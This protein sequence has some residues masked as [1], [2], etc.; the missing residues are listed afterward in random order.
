MK[1][2]WKG[3]SIKPI[4]IGYINLFYRVYKKVIKRL[5]ISALSQRVFMKIL[6]PTSITENSLRLRDKVLSLLLLNFKLLR[7]NNFNYQIFFLPSVTA[8]L[9][10]TKKRSNKES[11]KQSKK[12]IQDKNKI[13]SRW[14][15]VLPA[16]DPNW[17]STALAPNLYLF[18][19]SF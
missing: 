8:A 13:T 17:Y 14:I 15:F 2:V 1:H 16:P 9:D 4:Y 12:E 6:F 11:R 10:N 7:V 3:F 5:Y 18:S 19:C